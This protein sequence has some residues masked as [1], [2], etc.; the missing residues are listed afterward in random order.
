MKRSFF[1]C[2][3]LLSIILPFRASDAVKTANQLAHRIA[4][5]IADDIVFEQI[6]TPV[7]SF[8]VT[9]QNGKVLIKG[10]NPIAMSVGLN[11]FLRNYMGTYVSWFANKPI[12]IDGPVVLPDAANPLTGK[13]VVPERFFLNYCTF[14][15]TFPFWKWRD[16]ERMIDWMAMNGINLPLAMTGQEKVWFETWKKLGLDDEAI[17]ASFT[18]PAHLPWHWMANVDHFQGP[19]SN[20]WLSSNEEL[21]KRILERERELGMKPV[22]PAFAGHVPEAFKKMHPE[23][24]ITLR[25]EWGRFKDQDRCWFLDPSDPLYSQIQKTFVALQ[26][27]I[28]GTD[29]IY[30][31]DPFNEVDSPDW[32]EGFLNKASANI[33]NTLREADPYARWLQMTWNFYYDRKNW[34]KPRVKAFLDGVPDDNLILLD[35]FCDSQPVWKLSDSY[36]GKPYIWC[37]LG[38][39][40]GNTMLA[41][42]LKDVEE[43]ISDFLM[44]GGD[45][46]VGIGGTL[47]GFDVNPVMHE[48]VFAKVWTP[49]L[50]VDEWLSLWADS[51]GAKMDDKVAK[52]WKI[53]GDSVYVERC[54]IGQSAL[55]NARPALTGKTGH[56][57]NPKYPYTDKTLLS[58]LDSLLSAKGIENNSAFQFD[59]MNVTRQLLGNRFTR[60]RDDFTMAYECGNIDSAR[61]IAQQMDLL[62]KDLDRL[63]AT[64]PDY[65]LR[66][67]IE[68]ARSNGATEAEKDAYELNARTILT[69]WGY[70]GTQL[71]DY[72]NRQWSGLIDGFYRGRWHRFTDA[73]ISHMVE[74]IPFS[75]DDFRTQIV[76][77]EDEWASSTNPVTAV[78]DENPVTLAR[79]YRNKYF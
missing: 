37:Y 27:S 7:D 65:S 69:Q 34:T 53:L 35:Y 24:N 74:G 59:V 1:T 75:Q 68:L 3:F 11:N 10:N 32:S 49:R 63:M 2:L 58:V 41:G 26:D 72:A 76:E 28:Y 66:P 14:G 12:Q 25:S 38:N 54:G 13:A 43:K 57:T 40:G 8:I 23:A 22:M 62:L 47:E 56:Y 61:M 20:E 42:N 77:W 9:S 51:R 46:A 6:D 29:H 79:I 55:T 31:I 15:Y 16:W 48:F 60:L 39:F 71:N 21:Q 52:A 30:G 45:N 44:N 64:D 4:P 67:W 19:L 18:G 78:S 33:Y 36:F 5:A 73:V 50:T 17:L 70:P